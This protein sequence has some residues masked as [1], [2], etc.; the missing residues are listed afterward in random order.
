MEGICEYGEKRLHAMHRR[1]GDEA[2]DEQRQAEPVLGRKRDGDRTI[3]GVDWRRIGAIPI[4]CGQFVQVKAEAFS[5]SPL[6][7][8][9]ACFG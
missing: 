8:Y 3:S 7:L 4:L 9:C 6:P 5:E 2:R 1:E